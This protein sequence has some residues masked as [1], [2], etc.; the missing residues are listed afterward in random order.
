MIY[1]DIQ[2]QLNTYTNNLQISEA[3]MTQ[4]LCNIK[5]FGTNCLAKNYRVPYFSYVLRDKIVNKYMSRP[6]TFR[7]LSLTQYIRCKVF[8]L[9]LFF[10]SK[11]FDFPNMNS[12]RILL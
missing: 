2:L 3:E 7:S 6:A 10:I 4:Y 5:M 12:F 1:Q 11:R 8:H 9:H